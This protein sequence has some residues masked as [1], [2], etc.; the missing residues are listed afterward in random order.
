MGHAPEG[1]VKRHAISRI[2]WGDQAVYLFP[3]HEVIHVRNSAGHVRFA[4]K[5]ALSSPQL[6]E[7]AATMECQIENV[8]QGSLARGV[9]NF[10]RF[11]PICFS[12]LK[13]QESS[14]LFPLYVV[15]CGMCG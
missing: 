2:R 1:L 13:L 6:S 15:C 9:R 4:Y 14:D 3:L 12:F 10:V 7:Q 11:T 5:F 8:Q